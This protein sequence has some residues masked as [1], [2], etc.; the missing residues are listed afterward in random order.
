MMNIENFSKELREV[1][2][3]NK[4]NIIDQFQF[5]ELVSEELIKALRSQQSAEEALRKAQE[6]VGELLF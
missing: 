4:G 3:D 5:E 1:I 2:K 6:K